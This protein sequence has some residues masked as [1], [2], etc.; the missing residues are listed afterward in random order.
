MKVGQSGFSALLAAKHLEAQGPSIV[1]RV[2]IRRARGGNGL[3]VERRSSEGVSERHAA[4][5]VVRGAAA[6]L[7]LG[8]S[9]RARVLPLVRVTLVRDLVQ[10]TI[11]LNGQSQSPV[12]KQVQ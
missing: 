2:R 10:G 8:V 9:L 6:I 7:A 5:V 1:Q 3:V 11:Q 4:A 12:L